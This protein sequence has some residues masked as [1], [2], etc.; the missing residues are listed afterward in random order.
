MCLILTK[1]I[2]LFNFN[3]LK[4]SCFNLNISRLNFMMIVGDNPQTMKTRLKQW[5]QVVACSVRQ[6][7]SS[8]SSSSS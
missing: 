2:F 3:L 4:E 6:S 1:I 5:A 8:S 7:S